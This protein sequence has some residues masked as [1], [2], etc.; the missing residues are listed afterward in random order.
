MKKNW[1]FQGKVHLDEEQRRL[2]HALLIPLLVIVLIVVIVVADRC[3]RKAPVEPSSETESTAMETMS[4]S[5]TLSES[6]ET[7]TEAPTT[8]AET[9]TADAFET[10]NF[11]RDSI[12]EILDLMKSYFQAREAADAEAMN[13]LYGI[14]EEDMSYEELEAKRTRMRSNSKYVTGFEN[15][16]TYVRPGKT[17]DSWLVYTIADIKFRSVQ[18]AAPMI[19]WV[20]VTKDAEGNYLLADNES[21]PGDVLDYVSAASRTDEVRRLAADVNDRLKAALNEDSDLKQVYGILN[22][23]SPLWVDD[24]QNTEPEV[25]ILDEETSAG[26]TDSAESAGQ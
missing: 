10:E 9:E 15:I 20:Y 5:E 13:R 18:T 21:L 19:M 4:S 2:F 22:S 16:A 25:V 1:K 12:P 26:D 11:K 17:T 6:S 3:G 7:E 14:G 8:E 24:E 23:D